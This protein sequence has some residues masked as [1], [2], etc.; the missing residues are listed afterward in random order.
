MY[1]YN[2]NYGDND[3]SDDEKI[4]HRQGLYKHIITLTPLTPLKTLNG[5]V[6]NANVVR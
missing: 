2:T 6:K 4:R 1:E 3:N 5:T